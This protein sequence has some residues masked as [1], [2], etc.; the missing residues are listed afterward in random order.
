MVLHFAFQIYLPGLRNVALIW[1]HISTWC[2]YFI[3]HFQIVSTR[4]KRNGKS[5][6]VLHFAFQT[7]HPGLRNV[8]PI[9]I[10]ISTWCTFFNLHL[11]MVAPTCRL[12]SHDSNPYTSIFIFSLLI[13]VFHHKNRDFI[14]SRCQRLSSF[15]D[16][17]GA[18]VVKQLVHHTMC[19]LL[20]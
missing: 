17:H 10:H 18:A 7:Y 14:L 8:A 19:L 3:L 12:W 1:I 2:T 6:V 9:W 20:I 15:Q 4:C 11:Q 5:T 13:F 16:T